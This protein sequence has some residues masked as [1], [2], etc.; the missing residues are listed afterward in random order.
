M[1]VEAPGR[2]VTQQREALGTVLHAHLDAL[3]SHGDA[4]VTEPEL[5]GT[6][7]ATALPV[8]LSEVMH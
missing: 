2:G 8:W 1:Q 3:L 7:C 6:P 5:P 4:A